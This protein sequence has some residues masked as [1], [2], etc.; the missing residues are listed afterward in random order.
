MSTVGPY[1]T[2]TRCVFRSTLVLEDNDADDEAAKTEELP[3]R[4]TST[5][6]LLKNERVPR[7]ALRVPPTLSAQ[8]T[9]HPT[10]APASPQPR[11]GQIHSQNRHDVP[12]GVDDRS[13]KSNALTPVYDSLHP[14]DTPRQKLVPG[15]QLVKRT[16]V[17]AMA[18][19]W[20]NSAT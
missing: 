13:R 2:D 14:P 17:F 19:L 10:N 4:A 6:L 3:S 9:I 11:R 16:E 8:G 15:Q 20:A 18:H 7:S 1:T 12:G 5:V